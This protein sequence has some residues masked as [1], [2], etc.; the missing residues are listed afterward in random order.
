MITNK[1]E[2]KD[3][4]TQLMIQTGTLRNNKPCYRAGNG[5]CRQDGRYK[6]G[7]GTKTS[8][9][10]KN[11]GMLD[12]VHQIYIR[13]GNLDNKLNLFISNKIFMFVDN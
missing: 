7:T 8:P 13:L 2:C 4:C 1:Q 10:C 6:V 11:T 12:I 5:K 3:G 9:I